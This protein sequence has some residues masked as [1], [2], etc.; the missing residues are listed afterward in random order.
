MVP[1]DNGACAPDP[2][3]RELTTASPGEL[4]EHIMETKAGHFDPTELTATRLPW[5]RCSDQEGQ[6][7]TG[8]HPSSTS[9]VGP[10]LPCRS[11]VSNC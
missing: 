5:S 1:V 4:A 10:Q 6:Q 3:L 9:P 8:T 11:C 2:A 7:P